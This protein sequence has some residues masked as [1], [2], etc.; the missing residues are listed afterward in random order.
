MRLAADPRISRPI[1]SACGTRTFRLPRF[2]SRHLSLGGGDGGGGGAF[3][4]MRIVHTR[5]DHARARFVRSLTRFPRSLI[6]AAWAA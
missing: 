1:L 5:T 4:K 3:E 2:S 6:M